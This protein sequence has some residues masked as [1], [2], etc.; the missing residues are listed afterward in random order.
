MNRT[1]SLP[2]TQGAS[3]PVPSQSEL[4]GSGLGSSLWASRNSAYIRRNV[5]DDSAGGGTKK[6][7]REIRP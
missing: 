4:L 7:Y 1:V 2:V 5:Q 6:S 3:S